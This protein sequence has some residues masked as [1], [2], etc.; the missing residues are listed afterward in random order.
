MTKKYTITDILNAIQ[1]KKEIE[2]NVSDDISFT[3]DK[4]KI[5]SYE[6]MLLNPKILMNLENGF[7]F[8]KIMENVDLTSK[9]YE[10]YRKAVIKSQVN[11]QLFD[12]NAEKQIIE[13]KDEEEAK[14]L[15]DYVA[16]NIELQT[17]LI[18][19]LIEVHLEKNEFKSK[20]E[21]K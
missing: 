17:L 1:D 20:F 16:T 11:L 9:I 19:K 5:K 18:F 7:D 21:K 10:T 4:S 13:S 12:K 2:I 3:I 8:K 14:S 6:I 15:Y